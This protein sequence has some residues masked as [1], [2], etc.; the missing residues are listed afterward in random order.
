MEETIYVVEE[1]ENE[2]ETVKVRVSRRQL[3]SGY[4]VISL[5]MNQQTIRKQ[6]EM[7]FVRGRF[8]HQL[9]IRLQS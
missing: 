4:E 3:F 1:D 2:E 6:E 5:T 8:A 7:L 9:T